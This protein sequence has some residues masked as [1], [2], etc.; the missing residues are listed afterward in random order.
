[1]D[2]ADEGSQGEEIQPQL[3]MA[4]PKSEAAYRLQFAQER[5]HGL[6]L[7]SLVG[8]P[9]A[10]AALALSLA[11]GT[12]VM[13][14]PSDARLAAALLV[15]V[16]VASL[17][18]RQAILALSGRRIRAGNEVAAWSVDRARLRWLEIDGHP[19]LPA[20]P[21]EAMRRLEGSAG[22]FER[23]LTANYRLWSGDLVGASTALA[24]WQPVSQAMI[25]RK[26]L[27]VAELDYRSTGVWD[28]EP[29]RSAADAISDT[30]DR[31]EGLARLDLEEMRRRCERGADIFPPLIHA[32]QTLGRISYAHLTR[33]ERPARLFP[34]RPRLLAFAVA[35]CLVIVGVAWLAP[36]R[37]IVQ[38]VA[39]FGL[40]CGAVI[41]ARAAIYV[42]RRGTPPWIPQSGTWIP[43]SPARGMVSVPPDES[44]LVEQFRTERSRV[45]TSGSAPVFGFC[46]IAVAVL[47]LVSDLSVEVPILFWWCVVAF[48]FLPW[49]LSRSRRASQRRFVPAAEVACYAFDAERRQWQSIDGSAETPGSAREALERIGA[50]EDDIA[51][52]WRIRALAEAGQLD[53]A[54]RAFGSWRTQ[55]LG[56]RVG[57]ARLGAWL[58]EWFLIGDRAPD[59]AAIRRAADELTD[60]SERSDQLAL[61][62]MDE[63]RLAARREEPAL[64]LLAARRSTMGPLVCRTLRGREDPA[65]VA[66]ASRR[67]QR[68]A[69]LRGCAAA[70]VLLAIAFVVSR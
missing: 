14:S 45:I 33:A 20:T 59:H 41:E 48:L 61:L 64:D 63:A 51:T 19:V 50:R 31:A 55:E 54:A 69:W 70:T 34:A 47:F 49:L 17:P 10:V 11:H 67:S 46:A 25:A 9:V 5:R 6:R 60:Q 12:W 21:G 22:D 56:A 29:A 26:A 38:E 8:L 3:P 57:R 4:A 32:R 23:A 40:L 16:V 39:F 30:T 27:Q 7:A 35:V 65:I 37:G 36:G 18:V 15:A 1:M 68:R 43:A 53:N 2:R 13:T 28:S 62:A 44:P 52:Y 24:G 58:H 66:A 42:W